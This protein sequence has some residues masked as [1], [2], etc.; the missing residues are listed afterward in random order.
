MTI[1][2]LPAYAQIIFDGYS[3]KIEPAM[4]RS[5]FDDGYIRQEAKASRRRI[6]RDATLKLCSLED[7]QDF[8]CWLRDD[9]NN[10]ARWFLMF[11]HVEQRNVRCRFVE[12]TI[13]FTPRTQVQA[14]ARNVWLADCSIESWY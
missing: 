3:E 12:G 2:T 6:V 8:K 5:E 4:L 10:A 11:D 9:L 14:A 13:Q 7:L 1:Q